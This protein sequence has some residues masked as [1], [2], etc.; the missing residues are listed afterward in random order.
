M[1]GE[2][3]MIKL[4]GANSNQTVTVQDLLLS[5]APRT[6]KMACGE[7]PK[8]VYGNRGEMPATRLGNVWVMRQTFEEAMGLIEQQNNWCS[9][10]ESERQG[11]FPRPL[12]LDGVVALL[13]GKA[14][15]H[16]HCY[17]VCDFEM[18]IR[19]TKEF[20]FD[21]TAFHHALEAYKIADTIA[22]EGIA[23]A[24][25]A[26]SWGFKL[27]AY[28]TSVYQPKILHEAG[29][30]VI[31]KSDHPVLNSRF[32]ILEA[33]KAHHYGLP[34]QAAI[35]SV[36]YNP[37]KALGLEDRIGSLAV[38]LEADVV[39]WDMNPL[40]LGAQPLFTVIDG[41]MYE[42][43]DEDESFSA[44]NPGS[45]VGFAASQSSE[46]I[47][48]QVQETGGQ[49]CATDEPM[50]QACTAMVR[51]TAWTF[52]TN[53]TQPE[54]GVTAVVENGIFTCIGQ[55]EV[56]PDCAV[57]SFEDDSG[58]LIPGLLDGLSTLGQEVE[59][60]CLSDK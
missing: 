26:T 19:L 29:V 14:Q 56:P 52:N 59:Y 40:I 2:G 5:N 51:V 13:R 49:L 17:T 16:N 54:S 10:K 23:V 32:L 33:A 53:L 38:G 43:A 31:L 6:L 7:N 18:M 11:A 36:T 57:Y 58:V 9:Q 42:D 22:D 45:P 3:V 47:T 55:C 35:A 1:G 15:L 34:A 8:R 46:V 44:V 41:V 20:G 12:N 25:F 21:I 48:T 28:E 27:E 50:T 39:L 60:R 30:D 4:R 37:A 24:T